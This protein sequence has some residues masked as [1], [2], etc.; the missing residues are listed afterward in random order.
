MDSIDLKLI[1]QLYKNSRTCIKELAE[2]VF[3]SSPATTARIEKLVKRKII[4]AFY[5]DVDFEALGANCVAIV[6]F[7]AQRTLPE[8][9]DSF[10]NEHP[11]IT[12]C[13]SV[14][15][16]H[17]HIMKVAFGTP[18]KLYDFIGNLNR[19]GKADVNIIMES[20]KDKSK[21][22]LEKLMSSM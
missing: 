13:F 3:L 16:E 15:G 21:T 20:V 14:A 19:Y 11:N 2:S 8:N 12:E 9:F 5:A 10:I 18:K 6:S 1:T 17:T 4:K 22:D 7:T